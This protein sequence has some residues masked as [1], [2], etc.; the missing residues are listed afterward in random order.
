MRV[1]LR[2]ASR[3]VFRQKGKIVHA[4]SRSVMSRRSERDDEEEKRAG[5]PSSSSL[6]LAS[7]TTF[8]SAYPSYVTQCTTADPPSL[9]PHLVLSPSLSHQSTPLQPPQRIVPA[10]TASLGPE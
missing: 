9:R 10:Q 3:M 2:R 7:I 5:S 6:H 8:G 4:S 1:G